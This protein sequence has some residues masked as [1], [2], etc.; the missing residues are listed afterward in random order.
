MQVG[1]QLGY[2]NLHGIPDA[3]F[4]RRETQLA[5]EP[6][7]GDYEI[8]ANFSYGGMPYEIVYDQMR[9][10]ANKLLPRLKA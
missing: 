8:V 6:M 10:F 5:I 3:E 1:L 4:F 9:R 2:H 7:V